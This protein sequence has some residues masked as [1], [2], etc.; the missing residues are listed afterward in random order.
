MEATAILQPVFAMGLL[1]L[2]M[3]VWMLLTRIPEM[4]RR[5]KIFL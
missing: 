1:T 5:G 4:N 2:G 3:G